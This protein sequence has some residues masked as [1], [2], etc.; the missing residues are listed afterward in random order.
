MKSTKHTNALI[1]AKSPY[2]MQH[3]HNPV[4]WLPW[5]DE[6]LAIAKEADKLLLISV[7]Y[8]ACH[9]CHVMAHECFEDEAVAEVMNQ[10]FIC[11]KVDREE[12]PDVD[13]VYM[14]AVQL[15]TG[16]G[17]WPL[18]CFALPDGRPIYGG[19]YFPKKQWVTILESLAD[20]YI[21]DKEKILN[22][23]TELT[24]G[25]R[26]MEQPII[27]KS[28]SLNKKILNEAVDNWKQL[29]DY[30]HGGQAKAPKF[31]LPNNYLFLLRHAFFTNDEAIKQQV[32]TTLQEMA[33]GG[34][35][36]QIGGGFAR[37]SVDAIWKVPH[38]EKMLYDNAQ[39]ISL[40]SEA[41]LCFKSDFYKS[42]IEETIA[43]LEND[44]LS[45]EGAY[46]S[47]LDA[48]SEGVEGKF[49]VWTKTE[50]HAIIG[51]EDIGLFSSYYNINERG[52]WEDDNYILLKNKSDQL[53]AV[54]HHLNEQVLKNKVQT[55][56]QQLLAI[57]NKR[58]QPGKDDKILTSWNALTIKGLVDAYKATGHQAYLDTALRCA[59][60]ILKHMVL[61]EVKLLHAYKSG[62]AYVNGFL[63]D[64]AF[65]IE[66][67]IALYEVSGDEAWPNRALALANYT[68]T[69]FYNS[70][71][72]SF[73]F[74]EASQNDLIV[75]KRELNDNVIPAS[76]SAMAKNL[77][78]LSLYFG[79]EEWKEIALNMCL[80]FSEEMKAYL[81]GYSN[82]ALVLQQFIYPT[83]EVAIVGKAVN[84]KMTLLNNAYLPN[85]IFALCK[86]ATT[87]IPL[88][89]DRY[90]EGKT[91]IY[92][93][94][95]NA[96]ML[97]TEETDV[98]LGLLSV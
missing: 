2:L 49:Y 93:C 77:Y 84:E 1:N 36:D 57:R 20:M 60:F 59:A 27:G 44:F 63:E 92:V 52:Y 96:C 25:I 16:Q 51:E 37:Y 72:I 67:F 38:F 83:K 34:I 85:C 28:L 54:E 24:A 47:A 53:F 73:Y 14:S 31:P 3:A 65:T 76:N 69:A 80:K 9:W 13:Q 91:V 29:L 61:E 82:Y 50:L 89:K 90:V 12:R 48:D 55:W 32:K 87:T 21:N 23:A 26:K 64:Y 95:N 35:Y 8:S 46:Y 4:N 33:F 81:G 6:T 11:I 71:T 58:V 7:G 79:I 19:T 15:M 40:Y 88:C 43:F 75:R 56:K 66:A 30:E 62:E 86:S 74:T 97:P 94:E 70:S 10:H 22:Y 98:A 39:L 18:N 17:G 78:Y 41:Y 45:P 42:I 68:M 5:N